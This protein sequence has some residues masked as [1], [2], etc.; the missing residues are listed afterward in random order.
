MDICDAL[1]SDESAQ[2]MAQQCILTWQCLIQLYFQQTIAICKVDHTKNNNAVYPYTI[3]RSWF[4]HFKA[5][6]SFKT[7]ICASGWEFVPFVLQEGHPR[8]VDRLVLKVTNRWQKNTPHPQVLAQLDVY[9]TTVK[10]S[11]WHISTSDSYILITIQV[12]SF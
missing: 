6:E 4:R 10:L 1:L 3:D 5:C 8:R 2:Q 7:R 12:T 11:R 9:H